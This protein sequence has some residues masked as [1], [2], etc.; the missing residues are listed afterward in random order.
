MAE[1]KTY[2]DENL[3]KNFIRHSKSPA[4]TPIL[5][6]KKKNES[7]RICVNYR[8][9]NKITIKNRYPLPLISELLNQLNQTKI[10]TKIN[11]KGTY[12][13]VRIKEEDE[14]KTAFRTRYGHFEYNVMPFGLTNAPAAFQHVMNNIFRKFLNNFVVCYLDDILIYSNNVEKHEIHVCQVLQKLRDA[15]LYA[16]MEKCVF[17]IT[18]VD[19]LGYIISNDGLMMDSKKV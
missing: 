13:L 19:F 2:I 6:V 16:K 4:G 14:W 5:F 3:A 18:Q 9:L 17:Y 15:R 11:L 8:E 1:L 10:Y 7:L 12:N